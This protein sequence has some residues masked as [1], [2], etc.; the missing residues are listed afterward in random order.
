MQVVA[1]QT[2]NQI[3]TTN[4]QEVLKNREDKRI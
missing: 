3:I 2:E 4:P 1:S